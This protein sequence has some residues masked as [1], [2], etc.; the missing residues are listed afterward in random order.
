MKIAISLPDELF[1]EAEVLAERLGMSRSQ[2]YAS[3]LAEHVA[4]HRD[5]NVTDALNRVYDGAKTLSDIALQSAA[6]AAVRRS[7]WA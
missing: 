3:A 1:A 2:L 5:G 4:R 7:E 6:H